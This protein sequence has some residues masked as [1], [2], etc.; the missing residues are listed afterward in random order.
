MGEAVSRDESNLDLLLCHLR[1][2]KSNVATGRGSIR[3]KKTG[4]YGTHFVV[5][6]LPARTSFAKEMMQTVKWVD[7]KVV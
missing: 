2:L 7:A 5:S 6:F 4:L 1:L 3:E